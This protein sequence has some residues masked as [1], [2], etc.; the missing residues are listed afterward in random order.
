[1]CAFAT[2]CSEPVVVI[3]GGYSLCAEHRAQSWVMM[4][5]ALEQIT[6]ADIERMMEALSQLLPTIN[7]TAQGFAQQ[8]FPF[9]GPFPASDPPID[10][11]DDFDPNELLEGP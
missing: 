4:F 10:L 6:D 1:M 8:M 5:R 2:T 11:P 7:A 3:T 9:T